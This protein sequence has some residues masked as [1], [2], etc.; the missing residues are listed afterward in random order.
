[1]R[2]DIILSQLEKQG[3]FGYWDGNGTSCH[4]SRHFLAGTFLKSRYTAELYAN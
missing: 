3:L 1:M 2:Y 4:P